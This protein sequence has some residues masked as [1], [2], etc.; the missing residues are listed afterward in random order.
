MFPILS[1]GRR[2]RRFSGFTLI[3]V[4]VV[5][6][7]IALLA[8]LV[9]LSIGNRDLDE[10]MT[11]EAQRLEQLLKLAQDEAALKGIA[12]GVRFDADGYRFLAMDDKRQWDDYDK[13]GVLRPRRLPAPLYLVLQV[14]GQPVPAPDAQKPPSASGP[15]NAG[16][17]ATTPAPQ[18]LI[19]PGGE[20]TAFAVEL[21]APGDS[22]YYRLE[23][24]DLGRLK[25]ETHR[26]AG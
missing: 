1:A 22:L 16:G 13:E 8:T 4:M 21:R 2:V 11:L 12:I 25:N 20:S 6:I 9:T 15:P 17:A 14:E 7:I 18:V 10:R 5:T 24:D 3:E 26:Q 19:L 23:S